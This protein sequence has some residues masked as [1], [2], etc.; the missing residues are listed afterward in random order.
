MKGLVWRFIYTYCYDNSHCRTDTVVSSIIVEYKFSWN[1]LSYTSLVHWS[2]I[3]YNVLRRQ[4]HWSRICVS[5]FWN[6]YFH[7]ITKRV[8]RYTMH[9]NFLKTFSLLHLSW[10][11]YEIQVWCSIRNLFKILKHVICFG[12]FT[13]ATLIETKSLQIHCYSFRRNI[14]TEP[15]ILLYDGTR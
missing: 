7:R 5:F 4:D 3:S 1:L 11:F 12:H 10:N 8:Y 2:A 13:N 15:S 14:H 9:V 6:Y